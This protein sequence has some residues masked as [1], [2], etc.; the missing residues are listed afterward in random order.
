M[1]GGRRGSLGPV[2]LYYAA[3]PLF[4]LLD[5]LAG[6]NVRVAALDEWPALKYA[7][8]ALCMGCGVLT[9]ARPNLAS[10][11]GLAESSVNIL[12]LILGIMLPYFRV[13]RALGEGQP[14]TNP[15]TTGVLVNFVLSGTVAL[16]A[17]YR[18]TSALGAG[19]ED[20]SRRWRA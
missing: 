17:F 10:L 4:F 5:T 12:L 1:A 18:H 7:Y 6:V 19:Y 9:T 15:F 14:V 20:R 8:Y 2:V 16:V 3:T 13:I 11:V